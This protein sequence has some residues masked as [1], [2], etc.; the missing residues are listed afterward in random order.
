[1][2]CRHPAKHEP[3]TDSDRRFWLRKFS[4]VELRD[5]AYALGVE[6]ASVENVT[7]WRQR[8]NANGNG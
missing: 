1:M 4:D 3:P 5:M 6:H 8:L 2:L 7:N